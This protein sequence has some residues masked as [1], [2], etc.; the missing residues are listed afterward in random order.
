M[1]TI[2]NFFREV[3]NETDCQLLQQDLISI[4]LWAQ[5]WQMKLNP[6]KKHLRIGSSN[7]D[8]TYA[9]DDNEIEKVNSINDVGVTIQSDLKFTMH[10][11]NIVKKVITQFGT[12]LMY[13]SNM[14]LNFMLNY[15]LVMSDLYWN[16]LVRFGHQI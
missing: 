10:C 16:I 9:L 1:Q 15:L 11:S 5:K 14:M 12:S 6:E 2:R 8:F 7:V 13:S 3:R 4:F